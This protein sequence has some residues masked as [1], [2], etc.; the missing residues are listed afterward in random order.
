MTDY[1]KTKKSIKIT[2][3][4]LPSVKKN[5]V[6][7]LYA[8]EVATVGIVDEESKFWSLMW[9]HREKVQWDEIKGE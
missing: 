2:A 7:P 6:Y 1:Y 3:T 4:T 8:N 5:K 9:L